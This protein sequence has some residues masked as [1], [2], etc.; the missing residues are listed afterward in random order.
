MINCAATSDTRLKSSRGL[1]VK[2]LV[3]GFFHGRLVFDSN[4]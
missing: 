4:L 1:I 3:F 2:A